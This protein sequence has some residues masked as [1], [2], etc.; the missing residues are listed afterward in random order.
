MVAST[1][2]PIW[3]P[4][5]LAL[6]LVCSCAGRTESAPER[7]ELFAIVTDGSI[8]RRHPCEIVRDAEVSSRNG[9]FPKLAL[10][11]FRTRLET[12]ELVDA[13]HCLADVRAYNQCF[14]AL[15]CKAFDPA[16]LPAWLLGAE[17]APCGCGVVGADRTPGPFAT[18]GVLPDTLAG[19]AGLLP[20]S[21]GPPRPV[22]ACPD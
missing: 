9:F 4:I 13:Q 11:A 22:A 5:G 6:C 10:D 21:A 15:P 18:R 17:G 20:I 3:W 1:A 2:E 8:Q 12:A 14:L 7:D 16:A 19:C